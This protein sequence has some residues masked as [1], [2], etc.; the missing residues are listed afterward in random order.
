[1]IAHSVAIVDRTR[2]S[3]QRTLL[4]SDFENLEKLVSL[5]SRSSNMASRALI[6]VYCK[7]LQDIF[8]DI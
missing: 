3:Q 2:W 4:I 5:T 6:T 8:G 7:V 1:M